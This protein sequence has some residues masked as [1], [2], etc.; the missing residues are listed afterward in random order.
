MDPI[1]AG[2]FVKIYYIVKLPDGTVVAASP[3]GKPLGFTVGRGKVLKGLEQGVLG[4]SVN[5]SRT[6]AIPP[7]RGYGDR[8]PGR[9][10]RVNRTELPTQKDI[11]VGRTV[12]YMNEGGGM[13]NFLII[14]VDEE[15]VTLDAN[16]P[17]AG[18]S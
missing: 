13:V 15:T 4:M 12:Q 8:D 9:V 7:V 18:E 1:R 2:H 16:H 3:K 10:I 17:F 14:A 11:K 6:I 5:Q